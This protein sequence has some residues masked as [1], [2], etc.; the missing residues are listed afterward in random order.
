MEVLPWKMVGAGAYVVPKS[1]GMG[2]EP[3]G[4]QGSWAKA[5]GCWNW[6]V[7]AGVAA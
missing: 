7:N 6:V 3:Q 4:P 2:K 1:A 5:R